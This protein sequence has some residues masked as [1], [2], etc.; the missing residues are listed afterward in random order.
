MRQSNR[1][2][3]DRLAFLVV[4]LV[5]LCAIPLA[6]WALGRSSAPQDEPVAG[7]SAEETAIAAEASALV[8]R[9]N[10]LGYD[11]RAVP[12]EEGRETPAAGRQTPAAAPEPAPAPLEAP[13][14]VETGPV[15]SYPEPT[16]DVEPPRPAPAPTTV[17]AV[18]PAGRV[19]EV[20]LAEPLSSKTAQPGQEFRLRLAEALYLPEGVSIP[21]GASLIGRVHEVERA[22][23]P[24]KPGR[25]VLIAEALEARGD[26]HSIDAPLSAD[27]DDIK[28]RG[29]HEEDA[30]R[31]GI[32]AAAGTI[33]GAILKGKEGAIAGLI[34]GG[35]GV[36]LATRGEDVELP[37]GMPLTAQLERD[38]VLELPAR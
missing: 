4:G 11:V 2:K 28:G 19:L 9:L 36:F 29:S 3:R 14:P 12:V 35:G 1:S 27:G 7:E 10:E 23:R 26:W 18:V 25:L 20:E 24:Q 8:D 38:L 13:R 21:A 16:A 15:S 6:V 33:L 37:A 22:R 34:L 32:G 5:L 30:Q 31:I 17:R